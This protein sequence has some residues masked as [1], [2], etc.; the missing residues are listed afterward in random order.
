[1]ADADPEAGKEV[2][3]APPEVSSSLVQQVSA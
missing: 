2:S 1:M 3:E